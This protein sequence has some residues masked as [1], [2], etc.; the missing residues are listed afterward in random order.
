[1]KT[2][3]MIKDKRFQYGSV[4]VV[5]T[6]VILALVI[7]LNGIFSLLADTFHLYVDMTSAQL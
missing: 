3:T 4:S 5:F 7:V 2:K 1:M 6:A